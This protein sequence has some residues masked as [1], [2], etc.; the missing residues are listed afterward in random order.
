ML[1][2]AKD[3]GA[4]I[5]VGK[6]SF[7]A[8]EGKRL[9]DNLHFTIEDWEKEDQMQM[10]KIKN[11]Y[12]ESEQSILIVK[13]TMSATDKPKRAAIAGIKGG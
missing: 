13:N 11:L 1:Q 4:E 6:T 3:M 10:Q 8:H 5:P 12:T 9:M 2:N 7:N